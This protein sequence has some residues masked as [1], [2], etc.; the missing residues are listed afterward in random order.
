MCTGSHFEMKS[1]AGCFFF[2]KVLNRFII[3][4]VDIIEHN[5]TSPKIVNKEIDLNLKSDDI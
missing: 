5:S 2:L 3:N 4:R 1:K